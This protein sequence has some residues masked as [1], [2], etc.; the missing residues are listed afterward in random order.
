MHT[1]LGAKHIGP[2]GDHNYSVKKMEMSERPLLKYLYGSDPQ[3][4]KGSGG[5]VP[6]ET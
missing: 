3:E 4:I 1:P 6:E 2:K 5:N